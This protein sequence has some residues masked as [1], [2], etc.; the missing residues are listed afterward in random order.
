MARFSEHVLYWLA[1][2]LYH[3]E[4]AHSR[5]MKDALS[6]PEKSASYRSAQCLRVIAA[7]RRHGVPLADQVV[8]D[9]GCN[10]G[11]LTAHYLEEGA[12]RVVGVDIDSDAVE[13]AR[14]KYAGPATEFHVSGVTSLPLPDESVDSILSY[15]VFE[16]VSRPAEMLAE[17]RRVLRS[18]GR[19]LIGT[20]GWHHPFAPH[21]WAVMPVPWAHVVFSEATILRTCRR[22]FHSPWYVPNMHDLDE[23]GQKKEDKYCHTKIS[24]DYLN[25]YLVRDFERVF[26]ES[27][28]QWR[29]HPEPFGSRS[30][31][32][33]K[34]FL[35]VPYLR[36]FFTAYFWAVLEKKSATDA[37][38]RPETPEFARRQ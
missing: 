26:Q 15:D 32:W 29:L 20:W 37:S 12:R 17:C 30:A 22:V 31:N 18:G 8:L 21:L 23:H 9:L 34:V 4:V 11:E 1:R 25:K 36:E 13:S 2:R 16:H 24:T 38:A 35:K 6:S 10:N 28:L 7:A 27:G 33:S 5:E 3:T 19:M 14:A